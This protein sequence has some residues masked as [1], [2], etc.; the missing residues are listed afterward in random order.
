MLVTVVAV[1][2]QELVRGDAG[3]PRDKDGKVCDVVLVMVAT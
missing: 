1:V 3:V 2:H